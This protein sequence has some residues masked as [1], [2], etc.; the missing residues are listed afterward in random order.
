MTILPRITPLPLIVGAFGI[1]TI[2][3]FAAFAA[4]SEH[5]RNPHREA[6]LAVADIDAAIG[7][8]NAA[9][10]VTATNAEPY[11]QAAQRAANAI[12]GAGAPDYD[13]SAGEPSDHAGALNHLSWLSTHAATS[14]WGPAVQGAL[15]NVKVAQ[16]HL[17]QATKADLVVADRHEGR[18]FARSV[19]HFSDWELL[20]LCPA[21]VL[22]VADEKP[23]ERPAVLAA[24]D[25]AHQ[26]AKP[27]RLDERILDM[28]SLISRT[29]SGHL[30][31][32]HTY[33]SL[34][35]ATY[36]IEG[37][38]PKLTQDLARRRAAQAQRQFQHTMRGAGIRSQ[39]QYLLDAAPVV[40]ITRVAQDIDA[41]IV[42]LGAVARTRLKRLIIGSTAEMLLDRL[43]CDLLI[44]KPSRFRSRIERG[45]AGARIVPAIPP[46]PM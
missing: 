34:P 27:A 25:P 11:R 8:L 3:G 12:I 44:V 43:G 24:V 28:A 15:V 45:Q 26:W 19:L 6:V 21:P 1:I 42:V 23:Y 31:A 35:P 40:G 32:V 22:L 29:L 36:P 20:R 14:A 4:T 37:M 5:T 16:A 13:T 39:R 30:H 41:A 2:S 18:H 7:E 9:S 33:E 38:N 17:A 10:D 46:L